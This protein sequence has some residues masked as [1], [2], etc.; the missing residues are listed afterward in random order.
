M[1]SNPSEFVTLA[2]GKMYIDRYIDGKPSGK[3]QYFGLTTSPSVSID[4]E[5]LEHIN[6]E[7]PTHSV[8]KTI[9]KKQNGTMSWS[10][11]QIDLEMLARAFYGEVVTQTANDKVITI[12]GA[13]IGDLVDTGATGASVD[14][15]GLIVDEDYKY[16]KKTGLVEFLTEQSGKLEISVS[17]GAIPPSVEAFKNTKLEAALMFVG[18]S[19]TG[20]QLKV[21]FYKCSIRQDGE[22]S[23]KGDDWL[24]IGF[25]ADILKDETKDPTKGSQFFK[26]EYLGSN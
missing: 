3:W 4:M 10:S 22:F 12:D 24:N 8:D 23:L 26:I 6:T 17:G 15:A 2:G 11:D 13:M 7:G 19:A 18:E 25:S 16:N 20:T 5:T 1:P 21:T 14:I 9:V